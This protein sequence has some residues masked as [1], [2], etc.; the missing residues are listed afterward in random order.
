MQSREKIRHLA[1][2]L[3]EGVDGANTNMF[4]VS[5]NAIYRDRKSG[6]S[7]IN[8]AKFTLREIENALLL[9]ANAQ[10]KDIKKYLNE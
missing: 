10:E 9:T 7:P 8:G 4:M 6:I 5:R 1:A 2:L 3:K